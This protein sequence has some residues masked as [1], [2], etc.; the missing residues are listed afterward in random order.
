MK[1]LFFLLFFL[2]ISLNFFVSQ[3]SADAINSTDF[4]TTWNTT[5]TATSSSCST[6]IRIPTAA[7]SSYNYSVDWNNDGIIDQTGITGSVTHDYGA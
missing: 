2:I 6:C 3:V 5:L 4:V 7:G 1:K